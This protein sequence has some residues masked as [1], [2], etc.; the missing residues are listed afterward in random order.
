MSLSHIFIPRDIQV[1]TKAMY[2]DILLTTD[3]SEHA[4]RAAEHGAV[5]ASAFDATAHVINVVDVRAAA[6]AFD[7]G[8]VGGEFVDRLEAEGR[9]SVEAVEAAVEDTDSVQVRKEVLR[10]DTTK[11]ILGYVERL[12]VD[13]IAMGTRGRR[14]VSRYITGSVTRR[15]LRLAEV[16][17]LTA[18][19]TEASEAPEGY[20]DV[21]VPTDGSEAAG[22]AV[23]DG[24]EVARRFGARVHAVSVVNTSG[25]AGGLGSAR[26]AELRE[27][28]EEEVEGAVNEIAARAQEAGL[29]TAT[30]LREGSPAESLL[31]YAKENGVDMIAMATTGRTGLEHLLGS[32]AERVIRRSDAPVLAV[33]ARS[34]C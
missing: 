15:V 5:L 16:P 23:D 1:V 17:V 30:E 22:E 6:G 11:E 7:A 10:G 19:A 13:L 32:T 33:N 31:E 28:I 14:G 4:L 2:N 12:G 21:L 25:I 18:R 3:G 26:I 8:G 34:R 29:E 24:V 27:S 9:R 20:D